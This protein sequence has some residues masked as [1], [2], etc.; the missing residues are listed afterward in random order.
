[1]SHV[2]LA[3]Q[4]PRIDIVAA[5][6]LGRAEVTANESPQDGVSPICHDAA[7]VGV[8]MILRFAVCPVAGYD[9]VPI[10]PAVDL[11]RLHKTHR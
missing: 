8:C 6:S 4:G 5:R 11:Q 7:V 1:M 9:A 10:S 2:Y 3:V